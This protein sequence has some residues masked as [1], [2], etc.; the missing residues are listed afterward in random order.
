MESEQLHRPETTAILIAGAWGYMLVAEWNHSLAEFSFMGKL[1]QGFLAA[2]TPR[3]AG[4]NGVDMQR[5]L[6]ATL[7]LTTVLMWIGARRSPRPEASR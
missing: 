3:T 7:V 2:V 6:P 4:F 5:M 1:S